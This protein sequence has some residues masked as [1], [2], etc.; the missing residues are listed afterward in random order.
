VRIESELG[1]GSSFRLVFPAARLRQAPAPDLP[2]GA[3]A[4]LARQA[5]PEGVSA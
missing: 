3:E 4:E 5:T 1:Q 2:P